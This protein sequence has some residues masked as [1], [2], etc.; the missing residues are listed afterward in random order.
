MKFRA[1]PTDAIDGRGLASNR[2]RLQL[3]ASA[4]KTFS[5]HPYGLERLAKRQPAGPVGSEPKPKRA[6]SQVWTPADDALLRSIHPDD[7]S[8]GN[9]DRCA[10]QFESLKPDGVRS[11]TARSRAHAGSSPA[12]SQTE[13]SDLSDLVQEYG[14]G[15]W[16][17]KAQVFFNMPSRSGALRSAKALSCRWTILTKLNNTIGC[18]GGC[19]K[20][21]PLSQIGMSKS[22]ADALSTW[23]CKACAKTTKQAEKANNWVPVPEDG[24]RKPLWTAAE[25]RSLHL[26][27]NSSGNDDS[28]P[29]KAASFNALGGKH[30]TADSLRRRW[31]KIPKDEP[32]ESSEIAPVGF[33]VG[34]RVECLY[35]EDGDR[36]PATVL[37]VNSGR[38]VAVGVVVKWDDGGTEHTIRPMHE[39]WPLAV[40]SASCAACQGQHRAH[41]CAKSAIFQTMINGF[42][43]KTGAAGRAA[44]AASSGLI[45]WSAIEDRHLRKLVGRRGSGDWRQMASAFNAMEG[46][47]CVR[48]MKSL[49]NRWNGVLKIKEEECPSGPSGAP[50]VESLF[51]S[52]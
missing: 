30:V 47:A 42:E 34:S 35:P 51:K 52:L 7:Q 15:N 8:G 36:Y 14:I 38:S 48:S 2:Q 33:T 25:D 32:A 17:H 12:W 11:R 19:N 37:Q 22:E 24:A 41:I 46:H 43:P 9:W 10:A 6:S 40:P 31:E 45:A 3:D 4:A 20:W 23:T 1:L 28:W 26:I 49:N 39:V 18:D 50:K 16:A 27:V 29:V 13:D 21:I 5:H 44:A